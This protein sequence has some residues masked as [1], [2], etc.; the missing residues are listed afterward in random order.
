ML[1]EKKDLV[2]SLDKCPVYTN[3]W[4]RRLRLNPAVR[5]LQ[6]KT[7]VIVV[8]LR[9]LMMIVEHLNL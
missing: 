8:P 2:I 5:V 9:L 3:G 1:M 4:L 7:T 6:M